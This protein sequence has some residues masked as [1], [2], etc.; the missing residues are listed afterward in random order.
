MFVIRGTIEYEIQV[1]DTD[2]EA[3]AQEAANSIEL[4][5]A[6]RFVGTT[7][8]VDTD[9]NIDEIEQEDDE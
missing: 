7:D 2:D 1:F 5:V 8:M 6:P 3:V 9:N 4:K